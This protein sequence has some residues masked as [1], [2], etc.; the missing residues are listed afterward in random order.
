MTKRDGVRRINVGVF[1]PA[2]MNRGGVA[3]VDCAGVLAV[4]GR[5]LIALEDG[6]EQM[7]GGLASKPKEV[8]LQDDAASFLGLDFGPVFS[9]CGV[10]IARREPEGVVDVA[11]F[12]LFGPERCDES[13]EGNDVPRLWLSVRVGLGLLDAC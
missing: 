13:F 12:G 1:E 11:V 6:V 10:N 4:V 2:D 8:S 7:R 3:G 5:E 9:R